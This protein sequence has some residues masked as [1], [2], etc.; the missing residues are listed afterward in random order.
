MIGGLL[1]KNTAILCFLFIFVGII[2]VSA[3]I[4]PHF[5]VIDNNMGLVGNSINSICFDQHGF[6]WIST[7]DGLCR[8]DGLIFKSYTYKNKQSGG[9][10]SNNVL[11]TLP[12]KNGLFVG[13][14]A[15]LQYFNY[16][17][18]R[19]EIQKS[20]D[21]RGKLNLINKNRIQGLFR[22]GEYIFLLDYSGDMFA[23][24]DGE[25]FFS[26]V[27]THVQALCHVQ[28]KML[29]GVRKNGIYLFSPDGK[30]VLGKYHT[31]MATSWKSFL[32]YSRNTQFVYYGN[33]IGTK[34]MAF[35]IHGHRILPAKPFLLP[36]NLTSVIDYKGGV[37]F[38]IDGKGIILQKGNDIQ[39]F[40]TQ[41]SNLS[42][43]AVYSLAVSPQNVLWI[44]TYR[45]G[46][47]MMEFDQAHFKMLTRKEGQ[48][49]Y[50]IVT[51]V[52]PIKNLVYMGLDGGGLCIYDKLTGKSSTI[53]TANSNLPDNH[54]IGLLHENNSLW[55]AVYTKGLVKCDLIGKKFVLYP[56]PRKNNLGDAIWTMC[57]DGKGNIWVG[58]YNLVVFNTQ[59][60]QYTAPKH[61]M[62]LDCSSILC[63][64]NDIWLAS[65]SKGIYCI[66]KKTMK[67][68]THYTSH[69]KSAVKLPSDR[70]KYIYIDKQ[71]HLW[72]A[73]FENGFYSLDLRSKKLQRYDETQGLT[74]YQVASIV[75]DERGNLW[76]ATGNGLFRYHPFTC[77]FVRF[78]RDEHIA[79][80]FTYGAGMIA[81]GE[82]YMGSTQGLLMFKPK[83]INLK[84]S[85]KSVSLTSLNLLSSH[86]TSF[87]LYGL[88]EAKL[89]LEYNQ[90]F[91]T[92]HFSVPMFD[93]PHRVHFSCRLQGLEKEWR[94]LG[95]KREV[96]YTN[97]PS[98]KYEFLVRCTGDNGEWIEPTV[99]YLHIASPWYATW[100]AYLLWTLMAVGIVG[101]LIWM[102]LHNLDIRHKMQIVKVQRST[103]QKLNEAKMDF[104]ARATH[105]LRTPVFLISAQIEELMQMKQPI[106]IP[107]AFLNSLW[108]N[109]QKLNA[110][111]SKVIDVR[112]MDKVTNTLHLQHLD[113]VEFCQRLTEDYEEL[114]NQ[115]DISYS[116]RVT[117]GSIWIDFDQEKLETIITNLVSNAFKYTNVGGKVTMSIVEEA[118][119]VVFS[120]AD[121]GIGIL[122]KMRESIFENYFRTE[123]GERQSKG[124][125]IG[126]GTVKELVELH[127]GRISVESEVNK[128]STFCFYIPKNLVG[129]KKIIKEDNTTVLP[130]L[131]SSNPTA[132]HEILIIDDEHDTVDVLERNLCADFKIYKAYDGKEGLRIAQEK[133][134]ELIITDLMMPNMDGMQFL[135]TL[136]QD[137][138]MQHIKV[139]IFTA[140]TS[141]E[142]ILE[143]YDNG[144]D[145]YLTK[146]IS[147]RLLRKR[148]DRLVEQGDNAQITASIANSK[149]AYTKE[150]QVFLLRCREIID[151]NLSNEDFNLD[152]L[153]DNM[154]MSHSGLYK[155]IKTITGMTLIEFINDYKVYKAVE[156]FRNGATN[157][158]MVGAKCGF[159]DGKTFR[160]QFKRKYNM[161][162]KQFVQEMYEK[163]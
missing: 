123:R 128:G 141:E 113:V 95:D 136:R 61:F 96:A 45:G 77:S 107:P 3:G 64:G 35:Q 20:I 143:A 63:K 142:D 40:N 149:N 132:T 119:R 117:P 27:Q 111:I 98:G 106:I 85:F 15:T 7:S 22:M 92:I 12:E 33:G 34:S 76:M 5:R 80:V 62:A 52:L 17:T 103:T 159:K 115:K 99:L 59:T 82:I 57:K 26:L 108:R 24:K 23:K 120:V 67:I 116:L 114:C 18:G 9:I 58:G 112:K 134:P 42:N 101:S 152:V 69:S 8:Y 50:D 147:I 135:R 126:L 75:E 150:E 16:F 68:K 148:I 46:L 131:A 109:S 104:Y 71:G 39:S 163:E 140:K 10:M 21:K 93:A 129:A 139:I 2:P 156:M 102:Y 110:L 151:E 94:D 153:A 133:L 74:N 53:S 19:F 91:F 146:P 37:V 44:G 29:V 122:E 54:V 97:V 158:E 49:S 55:L 48:I 125:G 13:A 154:A 30:Q 81:D 127:H 1:K 73:T 47:N 79:S 121:T 89:N 31:P 28:D 56:V 6:A 60:G 88:S 11:L 130:N 38:G 84:Q 72:I 161:P 145:A 162:P 70:I 51:A 83:D 41:N 155:R 90:N 4:V 124:D 87:N 86:Q 160:L 32:Y 66:D 105:E 100:W 25:M 144:A 157:V 138:K 36:D 43:D 14:D 78:G 118:D 65:N 137:K